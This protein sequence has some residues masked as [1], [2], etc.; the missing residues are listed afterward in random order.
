MPIRFVAQPKNVMLLLTMSKLCS[1]L[2]TKKSSK[3]I[4][5]WWQTVLSRYLVWSVK[6]IYSEVVTISNPFQ[7]NHSLRWCPS[8]GCTFAIRVNR[9]LA[10]R[11]NCTCKCGYTF[12]FNCGDENH[13]PIPCTLLKNWKRNDNDLT[14]EYLTKYTKSCPKCDSL[15]EK[16]GGCNHMVWMNF[17]DIVSDRI[18]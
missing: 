11:Q 17:I 16:N 3:N 8:P 10:Y 4:N 5:I 1:W 6:Q 15:I 2:R 7:Y 13:D 12:C 9:L 18:F 14:V